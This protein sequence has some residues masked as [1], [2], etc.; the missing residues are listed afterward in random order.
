MLSLL[1]HHSSVI[2][3]PEWCDMGWTG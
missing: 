2:E 3:L 1:Q